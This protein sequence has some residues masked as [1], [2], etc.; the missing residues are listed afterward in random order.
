VEEKERKKGRKEEGDEKIKE[1]GKRQEKREVRRAKGEGIRVGGKGFFLVLRGDGRPLLYT[2]LL[3]SNSSIIYMYSVHS[4]I[5]A[6][7]GR[8]PSSAFASA[9]ERG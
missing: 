2:M 7:V 4:R 8:L 6:Q 5:G 1:N 3:I 9:S